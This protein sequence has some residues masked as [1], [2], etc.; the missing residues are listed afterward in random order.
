MYY[1][2]SYNRLRVTVIIIYLACWLPSD[3]FGMQCTLPVFCAVDG[4]HLSAHHAPVPYLYLLASPCGMHMSHSQPAKY[5]DLPSFRSV[6]LNLYRFSV[7]ASKISIV[8]K[9]K[10][11]SYK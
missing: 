9:I 2:K 3:E 4:S 1:I 6:I 7:S 5:H 10:T 11:F 8:H